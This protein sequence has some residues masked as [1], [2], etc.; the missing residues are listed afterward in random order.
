V[1]RTA[2][3]F[4]ALKWR[5]V[6]NGTRH[7]RMQG[8]ALIG[9]AVVLLAACG[10]SVSAATNARGADALGMRTAG[11][12]TYAVLFVVW[13]FGPLLVGVDETVDPNRLALVPLTRAELRTG[14]TVASVIGVGPLAA[15]IVLG[16]L[17]VGFVPV[18]AGAVLVVAAAVIGFAMACAASR[19][20]AAGLARAQRSRRGRDVSVVVAGLV[21]A[22]LWTAT[23]LIGRVDDDVTTRALDVIRWSPPGLVGHAFVDAARGHLL[24]STL[25]LLGATAWTV[26]FA[27]WWMNGVTALLV[28]PGAAAS[29]TTTPSASSGR[30]RAQDRT[31]GRGEKAACARKELR[32]LARAPS[33]RT[34]LIVAMTMGT[35]LVVLNVV[36]RD[37]PPRASVL[38]APAA[39]LFTLSM[40]N[41]QLGY[42]SSSLWLEVAAGG[43]RRA[44]LVGR[45]I[46]WLPAL[47]APALP[48]AVVLAW[49]S[50]GWA[51]LPA[52]LALAVAASGV[53]L[54]VGALVSVYAPFRVPDTGSPFANRNANTGQGCVVGLVAFVAML[55]DALFLVPVAVAVVV[56]HGDGPVALAAAIG[57]GAL[58]SLGVWW[59]ALGLAARRVAGREPEL[60]VALAPTR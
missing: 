43:P 6:V 3:L 35:M 54:G 44:H 7:T 56:L 8:I 41:N 17:V 5:L 1:I 48:A 51:Y 29:T 18:G 45:S 26:V 28:D 2:R 55:V 24:A 39:A 36:Q 20:V 21:G 10:V 38:L 16:G 14:L 4:A 19:A 53:P 57:A 15:A 59:V 47:V 34:A 40:V 31:W 30:T 11:V 32:Y 13:V 42:D 27:R 50:G 25:G 37:A 46:G 60:L 9:G 49:R 12:G 33:R 58:W 23:Q 52:A 22:A